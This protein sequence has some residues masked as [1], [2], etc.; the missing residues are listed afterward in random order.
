VRTFRV[1]YGNAIGIDVRPD[2]E[3]KFI[4]ELG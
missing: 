3:H 1:D 2:G 4:D